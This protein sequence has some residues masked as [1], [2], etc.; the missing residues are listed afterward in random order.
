MHSFSCFFNS[1]VKSEKTRTLEQEYCI[2]TEYS[3]AFVEEISYFRSPPGTLSGFASLQELKFT[4]NKSFPAGSQKYLI[5]ILY[6]FFPSME[7]DTCSYKTEVY[8]KQ[9]KTSYL[10]ESETDRVEQAF[11][12]VKMHSGSCLDQHD[13]CTE[14]LGGFLSKVRKTFNF[15]YLWLQHI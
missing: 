7:S 2:Q 12:S 10:P 3:K 14:S 4:Y 11:I 6:F 1:F 8:E 15:S 13:H 9:N 5:Q